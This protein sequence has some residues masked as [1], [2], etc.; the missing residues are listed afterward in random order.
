[1]PDDVFLALKAKAVRSGRTL[2]ELL[3]TVLAEV[4]GIEDQ[5]GAPESP[6]V[7][8]PKSWDDCPM[9]AAD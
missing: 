2:S 4:A 8:A 7:P 9:P 5:V 3:R 1:M 6:T